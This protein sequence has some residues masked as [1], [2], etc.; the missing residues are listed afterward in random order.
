MEYFFARV[1]SL[2]KN[3]LSEPLDH[4]QLT[5]G[6]NLLFSVNIALPNSSLNFGNFL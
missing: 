4:T 2:S 6:L 1:W 5:I 3:L